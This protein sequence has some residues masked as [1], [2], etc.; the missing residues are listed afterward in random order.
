[1]VVNEWTPL[2]LDF[3]RKTFRLSSKE[4]EASCLWWEEKLCITNQRWD[5]M[6]L[7]EVLENNLYVECLVTKKKFEVAKVGRGLIIP[8]LE[9]RFCSRYNGKPSKD[10]LIE[11][12]KLSLQE[13]GGW[14]AGAQE[15]KV[16]T[17]R[18]IQS[19]WDW[20]ICGREKALETIPSITAGALG[21]GIWGIAYWVDSR[22]N[23][24]KQKQL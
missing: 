18:R 15:I 24:S 6:S 20:P 14:G 3:E 9:F 4:R 22:K 11:Q 12:L 17:W 5:K 21:L 19:Q 8:A 2:C 1:M 10:F 23:K 16:V 13:G 7:F